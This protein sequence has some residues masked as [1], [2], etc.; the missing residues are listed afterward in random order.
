M[1]VKQ[2]KLLKIKMKCK[3]NYLSLKNIDL[4]MRKK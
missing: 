3:L 2:L 1:D 4:R